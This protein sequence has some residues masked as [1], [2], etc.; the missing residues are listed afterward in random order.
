MSLKHLETAVTGLPPADLQAFA[1]WFEEYLAD[2]RDRRIEADVA[3]GRLD[4]AGRHADA[5]FEAGRHK[6]G[7][8]P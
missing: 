5:G 6:M 7:N 4:A 8:Q 2:E 3:A 1:R